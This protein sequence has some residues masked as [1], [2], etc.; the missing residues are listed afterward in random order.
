MTLHPEANQEEHI[1]SSVEISAK[2]DP[3]IKTR[4]S[5]QQ[6]QDQTNKIEINRRVNT[7]FEKRWLVRT[8]AKNQFQSKR[9]DY[10]VSWIETLHV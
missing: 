7:I 6:R 9:I 4:W 5:H 3:Q 8:R 10:C 1:K 2:T